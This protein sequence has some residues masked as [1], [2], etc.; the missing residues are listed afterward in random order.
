MKKTRYVPRRVTRK[1]VYY[2]T[3]EKGAKRWA[4]DNDWP[5]DRII[6][7][8]RGYAVQCGQS[9][10]YAGPNKTPTPYKEG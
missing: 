8:G 6:L 9:G 7:Y 2:W 5:T 4:T 10:N 3:N 1:G